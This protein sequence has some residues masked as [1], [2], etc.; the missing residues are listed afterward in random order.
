MGGSHKEASRG[1]L[2]ASAP[3]FT[4]AP[5]SLTFLPFQELL[6][7]PIQPHFAPFLLPRLKPQLLRMVR[8]AL[9]PSPQSLWQR[10]P[11]V[12]CNVVVL[13]PVEASQFSL[14]CSP[15]IPSAF[16][17]ISSSIYPPSS[18]LLIHSSSFPLSHPPAAKCHAHTLGFSE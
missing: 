3:A 2:L 17:P 18:L 11:D 8:W 16:P 7:V 5:L 12:P 6:G 4:S 14:V 13:H 9:R 1:C 15:L 10:D